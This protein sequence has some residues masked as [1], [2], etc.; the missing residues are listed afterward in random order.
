MSDD[1][2]GWPDPERPGV[3]LNPERN[4]WHELRLKNDSPHDTFM[5]LW[6]PDH[7]LLRAPEDPAVPG[8]VFGGRSSQFLSP[9]GAAKH[10]L[11]LGPVLTSAEVEAKVAAAVEEEREACAAVCEAKTTSR[12]YGSHADVYES[13]AASFRARGTPSAEYSEE[14]RKAECEHCDS[15]NRCTY[16]CE[17]PRDE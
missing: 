2:N 8:Y 11:Y 1:I 15:A 5:A 9:H 10:Y 7:C 13:A 16:V 17:E 12:S 14:P 6:S 4:A 3:P